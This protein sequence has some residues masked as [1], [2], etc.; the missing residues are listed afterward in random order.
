VR[1]G[2]GAVQ[3]AS[4]DLED[5]VHMLLELAPTPSPPRLA[6]GAGSPPRLLIEVDLARGCPMP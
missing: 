4:Q 3:V 5:S 1:A 2:F 6:V